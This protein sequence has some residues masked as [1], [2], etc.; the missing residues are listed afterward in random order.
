MTLII[1]LIILNIPLFLFIGWLAFDTGA[2]A[3]AT[4]GETLL[5]L[6]QILLIPRII[7]VML[8]MD[9]EGALGLVPIIGFFI[10]C[11]AIVYGEYALI[12][13]WFPNL[14]GA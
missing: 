7:R 14:A 5:A 1:I 2:D 4:F 6:L 12:R 3:A 8:D 10:A 11:G 9:D 13:T